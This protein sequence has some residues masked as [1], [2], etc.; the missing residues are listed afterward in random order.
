[1]IGMIFCGKYRIPGGGKHDPSGCHFKH[2]SSVHGLTSKKLINVDWY[3]EFST[4][5]QELKAP[6]PPQV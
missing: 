6:L 2:F 4:L 5:P 1:M 3:N